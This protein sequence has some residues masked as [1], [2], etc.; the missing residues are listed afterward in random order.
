MAPKLKLKLTNLSSEKQEKKEKVAV[1]PKIKLRTSSVAAAAAPESGLS[2][3]SIK[4]KKTDESTRRVP[5]IRVKPARIPGEG[6]D[7]E[8]PDREDDPLIEDGIV[9]RFDVDSSQDQTV[10]D[11]IDLLKTKINNGDMAGIQIKW[12]KYNRAILKL[13]GQMYG[14]KLIDLPTITEVQ[15]SVDKKNIFKTFDVSQM[16]L[17]T[18]RLN[19]E[20]DLD[21][22]FGPPVP[23]PK[24]SVVLRNSE[25]YPHGLTPPLAGAKYRFKKRLSN[26]ILDR[27]DRQVEEL[28]R[29]DERAESSKYELMDEHA[30]NTSTRHEPAQTL[31][32]PKVDGENDIERE[33]NMLE[34]ELEFELGNEVEPDVDPSAMDQLRSTSSRGEIDE[35][36][37]LEA[38]NEEEVIEEPIDEPTSE[39]SD[40]DEDEDEDE[41]QMENGETGSE[42]FNVMLKEEIQELSTTITSKEN[43]LKKATNPIMKKRIQDVIDRLHQEIDLKKSQIKKDR[44]VPAQTDIV[45]FEEEEPSEEEQGGGDDEKQDDDDLED[46][47]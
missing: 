45:N 12:K 43:D 31:S 32:M 35:G 7:S 22:I 41:R 36:L 40:D 13:Q 38:G 9:I 15:K 39:S 20:S 14:G 17:I 29:L 30:L 8:D 24:D 16:L 37:T 3:P 5:R 28:L 27:V 46:L 44:L 42:T 26:K 2:L 1:T 34:E 25:T 11:T 4:L 10:E 21:T 6:Y 18:N 33:L 23:T 47:F 19:F